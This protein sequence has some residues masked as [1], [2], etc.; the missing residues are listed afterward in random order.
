MAHLRIQGKAL[1]GREI[2]F[3]HTNPVG[4]GGRRKPQSAFHERIDGNF[5]PQILG[6]LP[7]CLFDCSAGKIPV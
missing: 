6:Q 3:H 2:C 1:S 7:P 4:S 5:S